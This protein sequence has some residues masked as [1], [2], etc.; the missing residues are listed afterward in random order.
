MHILTG[1]PY[2]CDMF[3]PLLEAGY[4]VDEDTARRI[5]VIWSAVIL[6]TAYRYH[7][8]TPNKNCVVNPTDLRLSE[9]GYTCN[10]DTK[11]QLV[12]YIASLTKTGDKLNLDFTKVCC[13]SVIEVNL[14]FI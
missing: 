10:A 2:G 1:G 11:Q 5:C 3:T 12:Q 8:I 6:K 13:R 4:I 7:Y 14:C 9:C